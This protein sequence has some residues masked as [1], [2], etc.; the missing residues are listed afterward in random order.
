MPVWEPYDQQTTYPNHRC[1]NQL[2]RRA[3]RVAQRIQEREPGQGYLGPHL[4][5]LFGVENA[6]DR[7]IVADSAQSVGRGE[8]LRP[9]DRP[10][11]QPGAGE[12][13]WHPALRDSA[14]D[15]QALSG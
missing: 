14:D 2:D 15:R 9:D 11:G 7:L 3:P 12:C 4:S 13:A 5:N 1:A 8:P 6:H 10:G